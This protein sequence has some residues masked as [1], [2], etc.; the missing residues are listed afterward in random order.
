MTPANRNK[1]SK[2]GI[3][4]VLEAVARLVSRWHKLS[5]QPGLGRLRWWL[6]A[7]LALCGVFARLV[8]FIA[9]PKG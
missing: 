9:I 1:A 7:R 3:G 5:W 6:W 4:P 2:P 8:L